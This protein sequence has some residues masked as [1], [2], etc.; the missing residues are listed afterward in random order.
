[1]TWEEAVE[2]LKPQPDKRD[3]VRSAYYD[4]PTIEAAKGFA[5]SEEWQ[6]VAKVL[7]GWIPSMVLHTGAGNDISNYGFAFSRCQVVAFEPYASA[8][9]GAGSV[10]TSCFRSPLKNQCGT[11][12]CGVTA[13]R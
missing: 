1:M 10:Q 2:W 11:R 5:G 6:E 9:V 12:A 8:K 4:E 13:V 7:E 3:F